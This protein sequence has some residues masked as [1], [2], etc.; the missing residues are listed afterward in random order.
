MRIDD[1]AEETIFSVTS[2]K[3]RSALTIL[4]IVVGIA[5]V[6]VMVSMGQGTK[7]SIT[8]S[9]ESAGS[10]LVMV[11]PGFGGG[12]IRPRRPRRR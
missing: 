11:M 8:S 2:N 5:S 9:I 10:N 3:A 12:R 1:I 4:G 7:T 6:I